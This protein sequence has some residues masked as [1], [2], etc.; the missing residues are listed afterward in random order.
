ME[1]YLIEFNSHTWDE[2]D[3]FLVV[4]SSAGGAIKAIEEKCPRD[5]SYCGVNWENGHTIRIIRADNYKE[6]TII[7]DSFNAG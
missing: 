1:M 6:T 5:E 7:L 4:A 2:Y 3:S